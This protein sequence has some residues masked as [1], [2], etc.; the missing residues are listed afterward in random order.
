MNVKFDIT[1]ICNYD[2]SC[3]FL[4]RDGTGFGYCYGEKYGTCECPLRDKM[5]E[6]SLKDERLDDVYKNLY[7]VIQNSARV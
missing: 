2:G 3:A 6:V 5:I 4:N 1:E 7:N